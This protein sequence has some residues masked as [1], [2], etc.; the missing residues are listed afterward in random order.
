[1][2]ENTDFP[3]GHTLVKK[4]SIKFGLFSMKKKFLKVLTQNATWREH[5]VSESI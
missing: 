4:R 1:M 3:V 5:R 2:T